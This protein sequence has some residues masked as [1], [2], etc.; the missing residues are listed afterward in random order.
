LAARAY[1]SEKRQIAA[2]ETRARIIDAAGALMTTSDNPLNIS[3]DAVARE[4]DVARMTVYN[5]FQSKRGL[6]EAISDDLATRGD[7]ASRIGAAMQR[8]DA[9]EALDAIIAAFAHFWTINRATIRRLDA[10][11]ALNPEIG[12]GSYERNERRRGALRRILER[13]ASQYQTPSPDSF[14]EM[15]DLL[16]T[17]TSFATFDSLAGRTRTPEEVIPAVQ[18]LA[19]LALGLSVPKV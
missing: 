2:D 4:A 10:I 6:F 8:P 5:Q 3:I 14:D 9:L 15:V 1:R 17:I 12:Q 18:R 19:R 7:I 16:H 13:I 11:A